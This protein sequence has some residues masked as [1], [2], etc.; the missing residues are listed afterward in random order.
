MSSNIALELLLTWPGISIIRHS[1]CNPWKDK[2]SDRSLNLPQYQPALQIN[3]ID[4][5]SLPMSS[6]IAWSR[7]F[8]VA[9]SGITREGSMIN[10]TDCRSDKIQDWH[11]GGIHLHPR[12]L[13]HVVG[14][15]S[16]ISNID[17][18]KGKAN[19]GHVHP[20]VLLHVVGNRSMISNY[21]RPGSAQS[22]VCTGHLHSCV[23][24]HIARDIEKNRWSIMTLAGMRGV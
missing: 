21:Y 19:T 15:R 2:A 12:V 10:N 9:W 20:R 5:W 13:L 4:Y 16:M 3:I 11:C 7:L 23:L 24:L 18:W 14:D 17:S 22:R 8:C 1:Q 6:L